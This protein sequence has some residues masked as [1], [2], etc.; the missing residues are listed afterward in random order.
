MSAFAIF[1]HDTLV[2]NFLG[3]KNF[4]LTNKEFNKGLKFFCH[5]N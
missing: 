2:S 3:K 1:F 4:S 5:S